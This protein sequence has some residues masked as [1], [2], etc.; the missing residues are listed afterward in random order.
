MW[1][2]ASWDRPQSSSSWRK[3]FDKDSISFFSIS[4]ISTTS[5]TCWRHGRLKHVRFDS[6][7]T[8]ICR[9][10]LGI[11]LIQHPV[12]TSLWIS[13]RHRNIASFLAGAYWAELVYRQRFVRDV[14]ELGNLVLPL[15]NATIRTQ[16]FD[17]LQNFPRI[18]AF[19][20]KFGSRLKHPVQ[21]IQVS[22]GITKFCFRKSRFH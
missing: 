4:S 11:T 9:F 21:S 3:R 2:P 17:L 20:V 15:C 16:K 14:I 8:L 13:N 19:F 5:L 1:S 7:S 10:L 18:R 12:S 22:F 6:E